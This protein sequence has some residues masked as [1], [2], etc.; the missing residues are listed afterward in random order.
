MGEPRISWRCEDGHPCAAKGKPDVT[1]L[2]VGVVDE[3]TSPNNPIDPRTVEVTVTPLSHGTL[4]PQLRAKLSD[5]KGGVVFRYEGVQVG[6]YRIRTF[7]R[8]RP[9]AFMVLRE[10]TRTVQIVKIQRP[11]KPSDEHYAVTMVL[12]KPRPREKLEP[13]LFFQLMFMDKNEPDEGIPDLLVRLRL[14]GKPEPIE[15]RSDP[16]GAV[17]LLEPEVAPGE[18]DILS[19]VDDRDGSPIVYDE[20]ARTGLVTDLVHVIEMPDKRKVMEKIAAAQKIKRRREWGARPQRKTRMDQDW[21]YHMVVIHH[22]G[23]WGTNDPKVIQDMH[24]DK[25]NWDDIAYEYLIEV[26]GTILEGRC[27][28]Y[29]SA[30]NA[31][32]NTGK[33]GIILMGDFEHQAWDLDDD[34]TEQQL[35]STASLIRALVLHF[36]LRTL[37]GHR[38]LNTGT[39]CPGQV[40]YDRLDTLRAAT[41]LSAL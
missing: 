15:V 2:V 41:G 1:N 33:I 18:V 5:P 32:M 14:P 16:G 13:L 29:K 30:A 34:P 25:N 31:S 22:S 28:A 3:D 38:D 6:W 20:F 17:F 8:A 40:L 10:A 9:G 37:C 4:P 36:P 23:E 27:L 19:I 21:D 11:V 24:L 35:K 12:G 26:D 7:R 39:K